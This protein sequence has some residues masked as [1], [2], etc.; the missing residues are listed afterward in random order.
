MSEPIKLKHPV[1]VDGKELNSLSMRRPKVRDMLIA[2]K[3]GGGN[4]AKE[5]AMFANLCE[6]DSSVIEDL[7]LADYGELQAT[8]K[9]FLS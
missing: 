8:Y 4:G 7:D 5:V 9:G 6:V 2:D 3:H 1:T